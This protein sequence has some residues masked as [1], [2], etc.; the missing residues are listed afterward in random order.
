[1]QFVNKVPGYLVTILFN[2][3]P[4]SFGNLGY[5]NSEVYGKFTI[6]LRPSLA[7]LP[8]KISPA[9]RVS[10]A[11]NICT[12][13][14]N[15]DLFSHEVEIKQSRETRDLYIKDGSARFL[16]YD[17][18]GHLCEYEVG[19]FSQHGRHYAVML[20][21]WSSLLH[22]DLQ[23]NPAIDNIVWP[24]LVEYI[25]TKLDLWPTEVCEFPKAEI[26]RDERLKDG[27]GKVLWF[28]ITNGTG[29]IETPYGPAKVHY[30]D[31]AGNRK[32]PAYLQPGQIVRA[33]F[34]PIE[35]SNRA[36]KSG[37][38][39]IATRVTAVK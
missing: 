29:A 26:T 6:C 19:V 7:S 27:E 20:R 39:F 16:V 37:F 8:F 33:N 9:Y 22:Y 14:Q 30:S 18:K 31:I 23:G 1:M 21:N 24:Q 25:T 32:E 11:K 3:N 38:P 5:L 4:I 36:I 15:G 17:A 13:P 10:V 2:G 34:L 35:Q 12:L 28:K